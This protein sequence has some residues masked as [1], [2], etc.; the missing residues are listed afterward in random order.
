ME[1]RM[2][3]VIIIIIQQILDLMDKQV[4]KLC[5]KRANFLEFDLS[6]MQF[7]KWTLVW[8]IKYCTKDEYLCIEKLCIFLKTL[9]FF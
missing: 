1:Q 6:E 4:N 9:K 5:E 7:I 8:W 3:I 2:I